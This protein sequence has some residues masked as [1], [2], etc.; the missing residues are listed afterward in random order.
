MPV[1]PELMLYSTCAAVVLD[2]LHVCNSFNSDKQNLVRQAVEDL[3]TNQS[4]SSCQSAVL[5]RRHSLGP[6]LT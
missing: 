5:W 1:L 4:G 2:Y 6:N 3:S